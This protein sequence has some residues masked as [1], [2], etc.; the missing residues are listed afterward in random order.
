MHIT[1][2]LNERIQILK[3][4]SSMNLETPPAS[5][6]QADTRSVYSALWKE[7]Q[8]RVI[9]LKGHRKTLKA[10]KKLVLFEQI[11]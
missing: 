11:I 6:Q 1:G 4:Q 3:I 2:L 7:C 5:Q 9:A 10:S 8:V